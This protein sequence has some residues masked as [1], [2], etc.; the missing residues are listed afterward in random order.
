MKSVRALILLVPVVIAGCNVYNAAH[1]PQ[2]QATAAT[3]PAPALAPPAAAPHPAVPT[4]EPSALPPASQPVRAEPESEPPNLDS[5][6]SDTISAL[7]TAA[8]IQ[9][10]LAGK[11]DDYQ[12]VCAETLQ[13]I[14]DLART[15]QSRGFAKGTA[16]LLAES[17]KKCTRQG[18][19]ATTELTKSDRVI[20]MNADLKAVQTILRKAS[21]LDDAGA[22][23]DRAVTK[24]DPFFSSLDKSAT[25]VRSD[26]AKELVRPR[27][28][29]ARANQ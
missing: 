10:N 21:D 1:E 3:L 8:E 14:D 20:T 7:G 26:A 15:L 13:A 17:R 29:A 11:R 5:R 12:A 2:P 28:Y 16:A 19:M 4:A 22:Q 27:V 6:L 25:R 18:E 23:L 9:A 24:A